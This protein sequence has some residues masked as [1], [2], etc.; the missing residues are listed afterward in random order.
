[1]IKTENESI[2]IIKRKTNGGF[3]RLKN[4]ITPFES[5]VHTNVKCNCNSGKQQIEPEM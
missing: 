4:C 3:A 5:D 2:E 1:M